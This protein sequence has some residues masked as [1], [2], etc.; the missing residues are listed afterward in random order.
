[1]IIKL[2]LWLRGWRQDFEGWYVRARKEHDVDPWTT[3]IT[4]FI[5]EAC[6]AASS[7]S[8]AWRLDKMEKDRKAR[9]QY[10]EANS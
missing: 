2:I 9:K 5:D 4:G 1:M 10:H 6:I 8:A 3:D 7:P